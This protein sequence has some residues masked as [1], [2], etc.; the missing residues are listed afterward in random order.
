ML[1]SGSSAKILKDQNI[2]AL[3]PKAET[4]PSWR[5]PC[6]STQHAK[7]LNPPQGVTSKI[8]STHSVSPKFEH[9]GG[10]TETEKFSKIFLKFF[11]KLKLKLWTIIFWKV[12]QLLDIV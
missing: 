12:V 6:E 3:Y 10:P 4:D 9:P 8:S 7:I 1:L 2:V 11:Q 5:V